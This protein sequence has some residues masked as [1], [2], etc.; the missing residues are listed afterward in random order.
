[1]PGVWRRTWAWVRSVRRREIFEAANRHYQTA[2]KT[3]P[4][5]AAAWNNLGTWHQE[6]GERP[7]AAD[8]YRRA[9]AHRFV[10]MP[11]RTTTSA[12]CSPMKTGPRRRRPVIAPRSHIR[13]EFAEAHKN[14]GAVLQALGRRDEAL[15][16][17]REAVRLRPDF[18]EAAYKLAALSGEQSPASAPAEYVAALFDGYAGDYDQHLT[19]TL[20]YRVPQALCALL[21][22]WVPEHGGWMCSISVAEPA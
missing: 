17:F 16:S 9:L 8:C 22:E 14:R 4:D 5:C 15:A 7:A 12:R 21:V 20:Q 19:S 11:R 3:N 13:P 6:R 1:M 10:S 18:V 2:L